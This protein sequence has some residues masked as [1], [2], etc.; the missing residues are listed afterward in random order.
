MRGNASCVWLHS[1]HGSN[2]RGCKRRP[3][4]FE[5]AEGG[6]AQEGTMCR[7]LR[8][9]EHSQEWLC[10]EEKDGAKKQNGRPEVNRDARF[11]FCEVRLKP[12]EAGLRPIRLGS[13]VP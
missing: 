6:R 2:K 1:C 4:P 3:A 11:A 9:Q 12:A 8:N 10:H 7:A 5:M 13:A